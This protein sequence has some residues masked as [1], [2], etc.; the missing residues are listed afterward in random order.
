[1]GLESYH[2]DAHEVMAGFL[3]H[4]VTWEGCHYGALLPE[5]HPFSFCQ[6]LGLTA[7]ERDCLFST[8]GFVMKTGTAQEL[9][10]L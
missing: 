10:F 1:M 5:E 2:D 3:Q 8:C 6:L 7:G 4:A 9:W